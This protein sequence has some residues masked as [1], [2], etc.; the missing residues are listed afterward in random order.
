MVVM[1]MVVVMIVVVVMMMMVQMSH[2]GW[3]RDHSLIHS[4][5]HSLIHLLIHSTHSRSR[6]FIRSLKPRKAS[7]RLETL[8]REAAAKLFCT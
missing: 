8:L 3:A 4:L 5:T 7:P 2:I 1:M 6:D